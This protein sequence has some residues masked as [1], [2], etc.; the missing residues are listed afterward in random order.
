MQT[1]KTITIGA[2]GTKKTL[3][4]GAWTG[5]PDG[6]KTPSRTNGMQLAANKPKKKGRYSRVT[7]KKIA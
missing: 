5:I 7:N 3:K 2:P 6:Y 1:L 4:L